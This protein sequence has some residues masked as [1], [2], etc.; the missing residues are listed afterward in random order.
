MNRPG[1]QLPISSKMSHDSEES[2]PWIDNEWWRLTL[3]VAC[4]VAWR[5][6][7][8]MWG[9]KGW[10]I[11]EKLAWGRVGFLAAHGPDSLGQIPLPPHASHAAAWDGSWWQ[12]WF[13][14]TEHEL[15]R[16][17]HEQG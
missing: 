12:G 8:G 10:R 9:R 1:G 2:L 16:Q 3:W 14:S 5:L 15:L 11:S 17:R 13:R 6:H 7:A 4:M